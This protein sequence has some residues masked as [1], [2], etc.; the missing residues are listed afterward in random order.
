M[1]QKTS[2]AVEPPGSDEVERQHVRV[3]DDSCTR[4]GAAELEES[5]ATISHSH[6]VHAASVHLRT[7]GDLSAV[8]YPKFVCGA[9]ITS[10]RSDKPFIFSRTFA[11]VP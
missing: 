8:F 5:A 6:D 2:G 1:Q 9:R 3:R 7:C 4:R 10:N 11:A